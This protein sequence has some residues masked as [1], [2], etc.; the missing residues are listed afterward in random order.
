MTVDLGKD[1]K[2]L[3]ALL[4][5]RVKAYAAKAKRSSKVPPVSAI[6]VG[7][8]FDQSG[9]IHVNFDVRPAHERDGSWTRFKAR[10][11]LDRPHW[12]EAA[13]AI[14]DKKPVTLIRPDGKRRDGKLTEDA[15]STAL[16]RM[17]KDALLKAKA[18]GT[19]APLPKRPGCQLDIEEFNGSWAWPDYE[20]LGKVNLLE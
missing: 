6:E 11:L 1:A 20:K 17:I 9:W 10:D 5:E 8:C 3:R 14:L 18:D 15:F 19:F 2:A 4:D 13:E 16:G 12:V 7:Y